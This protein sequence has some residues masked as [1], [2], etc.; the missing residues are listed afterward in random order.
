MTQ[1]SS[2]FISILGTATANAWASLAESCCVVLA[3]SLGE[4]PQ[5][6][7]PEA[8]YMRGPGPKWRESMHGFRNSPR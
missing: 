8:Y 5:T 7:R 2:R 6:Y 3:L 4:R 1:Q